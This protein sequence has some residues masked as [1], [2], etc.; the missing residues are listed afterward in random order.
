MNLTFAFDLKVPIVKTAKTA[1]VWKK[2]VECPPPIDAGGTKPPP[3]IE[4]IFGGGRAAPDMYLRPFLK[5]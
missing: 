1:C 4:I 3:H 5:N 2:R